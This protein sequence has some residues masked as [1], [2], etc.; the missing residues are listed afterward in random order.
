MQL[1]PHERLGVRFLQVDALCILQEGDEND[2]ISSNIP[3]TSLSEWVF[4]KMGTA[5]L[6]FG[7]ETG[8]R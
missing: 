5:R 8:I 7:H 3:P 1:K 4:D 2:K 6:I